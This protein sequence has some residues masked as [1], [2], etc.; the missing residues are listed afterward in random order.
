MNEVV[1]GRGQWFPN[2]DS[3]ATERI[4]AFKLPD[5][6]MRESADGSDPF[7]WPK[8][9]V[10]EPLTRKRDT[11]QFACHLL[12]IQHDDFHVCDLPNDYHYR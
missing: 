4:I 2:P 5:G 1:S 7:G 10:I 9:L 11:S 12:R 3:V 6:C 8:G